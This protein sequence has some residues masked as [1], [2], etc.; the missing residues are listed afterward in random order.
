MD[1]YWI[2]DLPSWQLFLLTMTITLIFAV[3]GLL[4]TRPW[5]RRFVGQPPAENDLVSNFLAA[6]GVFYGITLGLI[7]AGTWENF[8]DRTRSGVSSPC[9]M[10]ACCFAKPYCPSNIAA[11]QQKWML[12]SLYIL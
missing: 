5:A 9:N 6:L 7:A 4:L 2:Y 1:L 8:A 10:R 11:Q 12:W 3:G